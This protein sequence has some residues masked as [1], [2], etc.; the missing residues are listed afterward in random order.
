MLE[1]QMILDAERRLQDLAE[2]KRKADKARRRGIWTMEDI[3]YAKAEAF[4]LLSSIVFD[5]EAPCR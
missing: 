3:D 2:L 5:D 1:R 4:D